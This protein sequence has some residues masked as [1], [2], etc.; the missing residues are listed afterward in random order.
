MWQSSLKAGICEEVYGSPALQ[1]QQPHPSSSSS[2]SPT[3]PAPAPADLRK[4]KHLPNQ[5]YYE[6]QLPDPKEKDEYHIP[7]IL[8]PFY[9]LK[10]RS[11]RARS[12]SKKD[13]SLRFCLDWTIYGSIQAS[14]PS[15]TNSDHRPPQQAS[16]TPSV[17]A[18]SSS[19][20]EGRCREASQRLRMWG[21]QRASSAPAK[22]AA[23][24]SRRQAGDD[25]WAATPAIYAISA[26]SLF[27]TQSPT[28][29]AGS[30]ALAV[31]SNNVN[32]HSSRS[33]CHCLGIYMVSALVCTQDSDADTIRGIIDLKKRMDG[34]EVKIDEI[35]KLLV[36][37]L[38]KL[39]STDVGRQKS[40]G[41]RR[42]S[43]RSQRQKRERTKDV[44]STASDG[45]SE[46]E[47]EEASEED[48]EESEEVDESEEAAEEDEEKTDVKEDEEETAAEE[49]EDETWENEEDT[50]ENEEET[51]ETGENEEETALGENEDNAA[52][53]NEDE[54]TTV[55]KS[56]NDSD[57]AHAEK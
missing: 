51:E 42:R 50:V 18:K 49:D 37:V 9:E 54:D 21:V 10:K 55:E 17:P 52:E 15:L 3:P 35:N 47:K 24:V 2:G 39:N 13:G 19:D 7:S 44:V 40:N 4:P 53:Q 27:T 57:E 34:L 25:V 8:S 6:T 1:L 46:E 36:E 12:K 32:E 14:F 22:I 48:E 31:G 28:R 26:M 45:E 30:S 29:V 23:K 16:V 43:V 41:R 20:E 56:H 5:N 33:H 11:F 38:M